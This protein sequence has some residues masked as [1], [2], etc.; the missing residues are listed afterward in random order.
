MKLSTLF[1][2][3]TTISTLTTFTIASPVV[4]V[5]K[6]AINETALAE[7]IPTTKTIMLKHHMGNHFPF[8]NQKHLL[9]PCLV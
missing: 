9:F 6:R 1:T 7:D 5:E 2:L 4:V 3:A 8:I